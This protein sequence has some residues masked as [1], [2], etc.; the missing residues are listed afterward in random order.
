MESTGSADSAAQPYRFNAKEDQSF[1]GVPLLDYGARF[2]NPTLARWT[3]PDPLA[4]KYYSIS[5][6]AFCNNNPVNLV[7]PDGR[8]GI[9]INFPE[10]IIT[11]GERQYEN[12]GHSGVLLID[13]KTG[14]TK[15]YEFGRY[16]E[17]GIGVV[18][19]PKIPDVIIGADGK[20]TEESLNAVLSEISEKAGHGG[21]IEGAYVESDNFKDMND[22]AKEQMNNNSNEDRKEY[23]IINNNCSTFAEDVLKQDKDVEKQAPTVLI[24][25]PNSV[26]KKWQNVF[27]PIRYE[28]NKDK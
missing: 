10:Y 14:V 16:D 17:A 22:Y 8:D 24:N 7:D 18:R 21:P 2:Y 6:Y 5:P 25:K 9:Y 28:P 1:T 11:I 13:N 15:Y 26:V 12:L 23:N 4:E 19:K 20:P 3:T 27:T